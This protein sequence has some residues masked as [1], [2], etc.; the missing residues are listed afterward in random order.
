MAEAAA[1]PPPFDPATFDP[2]HQNITMYS[3]DGAPLSI[4]MYEV[5][6]YRLY[7]SRLGISFGSQ[8]GATFVLLLVLLLLTRPEKRKSLIFILNSLCLLFNGVRLI[9]AACYLTGGLAHPYSIFTGVYLS[10]PTDIAVSITSNTLSFVVLALVMASLS[11]QVWVACVTAGTLQRLL[12]MGITTAMAL[13]SLGFKF[14][15]VI[16]SNIALVQLRTSP[17]TDKLNG[18]SWIT[19]AV[20]ILLYSCVFTW[21]LGYAI[22]QRRRLNLRQFGPIQIVFIMG[23]QTMF[24]PAVVSALQ[25]RES[26]LEKVPEIGNM[27][28]TLVCIFLPLSAIWAGVANDSDSAYRGR[29]GHHGLMNG[30]FGRGSSVTASAN[31]TTAVDKS[32]QM[33]CST[34]TYTKRGDE[35]GPSKYS[36]TRRESMTGDDAILVDREYAVHH[37][38]IPLDR[39]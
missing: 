31:S 8:L 23:C 22:V 3:P 21:K 30:E 13:V 12:I 32:R 38:A 20:A 18:C 24:V 25:F 7:V 6:Q 37:E 10:D 17:G 15:F 2:W 11:L 5:D 36:P 34:C 1:S 33:S 28:L 27:V 4:N 16:V 35:F 9:F 39:V 14:A 26:V 29:N 19:Q